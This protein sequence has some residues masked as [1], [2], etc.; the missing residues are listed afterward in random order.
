MVGDIK[1]KVKNN[2]ERIMEV[3]YKIKDESY[4][5]Y[6]NCR[7]FCNGVYTQEEYEYLLTYT[8]ARIK[9]LNEE[10]ITLTL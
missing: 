4:N 9:K 5:A 6:Q 2:M 7:N 1:D 8:T 3:T 10:L